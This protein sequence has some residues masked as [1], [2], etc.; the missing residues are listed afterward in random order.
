MLHTLLHHWSQASLTLHPWLGLH[1]TAICPLHWNL[2][3]V[4]STHWKLTHWL[5]NIKFY[6]IGVITIGSMVAPKCQP[7]HIG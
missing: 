1:K 2:P 3:L 7:F 5:L 4:T 6:W